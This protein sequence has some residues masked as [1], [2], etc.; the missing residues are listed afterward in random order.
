MSIPG[1]DGAGT[2]AVDIEYAWTLDHEDLGLPPGTNI[3][4]GTLHNP[5]FL[6]YYQQYN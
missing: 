1:W 6:F 3:D 4:P 5:F 2:T